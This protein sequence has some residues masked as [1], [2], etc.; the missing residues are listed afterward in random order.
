[1]GKARGLVGSLLGFLLIV[2][3]YFMTTKPAL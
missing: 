1:M 2:A 3:I